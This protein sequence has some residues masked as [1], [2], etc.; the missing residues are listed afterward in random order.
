MAD[1]DELF[2]LWSAVFLFKNITM[3]KETLLTQLKSQLGEPSANG[4]LGNTGVTARTLDAYVNAILPLVTSDEMVNEEFIN[5]HVSV[6]NAMGGQMR[7]EQADFVKNYKTNK[8]VKANPVEP[9][10]ENN[11][12]ENNELIQKLLQRIETI[13][14]ENKAFQKTSEI[15]S[16]REMVKRKS[17]ELKVANKN[18]WDDAVGMVQFSEGMDSVA[19][20]SEAKRIYENKLKSYMGDGAFPYGNSEGDK[21]EENKKALDSFFDRMANEGKF[22]KV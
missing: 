13:E 14:N 16:L 7:H 15:N 20:E 21:S 9:V 1:C 3:D 22:P 12:N 5:S 19:L 18:L 10:I 17:G 4:M 11:N 8:E 6:I 2:S